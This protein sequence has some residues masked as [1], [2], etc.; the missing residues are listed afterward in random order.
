MG[1]TPETNPCLMVDGRSLKICLQEIGVPPMAKRPMH[2][3]IV[4]P[5]RQT[6]NAQLVSLGAS[7]T[8]ELRHGN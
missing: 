7:I 2:L 1:R 8:Q 3:D 5:D 4:T 6:Q